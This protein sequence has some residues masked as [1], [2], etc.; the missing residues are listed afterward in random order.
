M[1]YTTRKLENLHKTISNLVRHF[2]YFRNLVSHYEK[3]IDEKKD[4]IDELD[5]KLNE[6]NT[7]YQN[8][9]EEN[10]LKDESIRKLKMKLEKT[11]KKNREA[12]EKSS[13]FM[14]QVNKIVIDIVNSNH[15]SH[16]KIATILEE[17][18]SLS[19]FDVGNLLNHTLNKRFTS[20]LLQLFNKIVEINSIKS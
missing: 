12:I 3:I 5:E 19:E 14:K 20:F 8:S 10:K 2:K 11:Q 1:Y 18:V 9:L 16:E 17:F 13:L 4:E 6:L 7:L 15:F